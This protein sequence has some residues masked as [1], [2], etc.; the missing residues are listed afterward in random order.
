[1]AANRAAA[2]MPALRAVGAVAAAE[3]MPLDD[4][5]KAATFRDPDGIHVIALRENIHT[6][7]IARFH[8]HGKTAEL[9]NA[10]H[11]RIVE[12]FQMAVCRI[13]QVRLLL[14]TKTKLYRLVAVGLDRFALDHAIGT[15]QH[16]RDRN[17]ISLRVVNARLA[18]FFSD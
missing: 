17:N 6:H 9:A 13:G 4:S 2:S 18:K 5:L 15:G 11:R 7:D 3:M 10:L 14:V 8:V 12:L 1:T 16:D